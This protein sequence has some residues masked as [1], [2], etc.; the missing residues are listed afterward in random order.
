VGRATFGLESV[1]RVTDWPALYQHIIDTQSFD[2]L[3]KRIGVKAWQARADA[4]LY[5]PGIEQV[6]LPKVDVKARRR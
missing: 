1:P 6:V 2:L 5:V 3:H 4:G